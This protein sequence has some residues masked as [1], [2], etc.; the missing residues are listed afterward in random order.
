MNYMNSEELDLA[1][2]CVRRYVEAGDVQGMLNMLVRYT[3]CA[4]AKGMKQAVEDV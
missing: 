2:R 3:E 4:Y 1:E